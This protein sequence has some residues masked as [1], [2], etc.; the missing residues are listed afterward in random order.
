MLSVMPPQVWR[1]ERSESYNEN[2]LE[3][4]LPM[5]SSPRNLLLIQ[6]GINMMAAL[7]HGKITLAVSQITIRMGTVV[8]FWRNG[9]YW[10]RRQDI[11]HH[12]VSLPGPQRKTTCNQIRLCPLQRACGDR[13]HQRSER[14]RGGNLW[15]ISETSS[16]PISMMS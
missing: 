10:T 6:R 3:R 15:T 4:M 9:L 12:K 8:S 5:L 2:L 1:R 11:K 7:C 14:L 13:V 16:L